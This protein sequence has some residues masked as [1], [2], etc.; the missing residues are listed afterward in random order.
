[1]A[2]WEPTERVRVP[3]V[4]QRWEALTFVHFAYD[5]EL[6]AG[7]L[8]DHLAPDLHDGQ[9]WV[10]IT[11]FRLRASVLPVAP[12][13]RSTYVEVNVR[14]YVR[15]R[16]GRDGLWF[17]TL[18]LDQ[19]AVAAAVR[20]GLGLPYRWAETSIEER[21]SRV[22][23]STRR[24]RPHRRGELEMAVQ[25][26]DALPSPP[27]PFETF[28]V[29]RWRAFTGRVGRAVT[30]PVEHEAWPLRRAQLTEWRSDHLLETLG[31]PEP[32]TDPHVLFSPG[33][34][35]KLGYPRP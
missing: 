35:V 3:S 30:V 12:G 1:M 33:V 7:L 16:D 23:Y 13:P 15:D 24:R 28:L 14:T 18:E 27:G 25:H 2:S 5:P 34:N 8:P 4:Q 10:G 31:L 22:R 20:L 29:G 19:P 26:G 17:L 6:I 9:A 11:P 21:G 32:I